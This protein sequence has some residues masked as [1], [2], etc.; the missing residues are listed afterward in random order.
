M[1]ML[2]RVL[3]LPKVLEAVEPFDA[4]KYQLQRENSYFLDEKKISQLFLINA[5]EAK[6]LNL[7]EQKH[8]MRY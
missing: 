4:L 1:K 3:G 5:V 7:L 8:C 6:P 2:K